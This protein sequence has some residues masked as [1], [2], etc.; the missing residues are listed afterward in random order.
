MAPHIPSSP[1]A[2]ATRAFCPPWAAAQHGVHTMVS[3]TATRFTFRCM[4]CFQALYATTD[5]VGNATNC[6]HC[7]HELI[8]PE[9]TPER[10][11]RAKDAPADVPSAAVMASAADTPTTTR[12]APAPG[13]PMGEEWTNADIERQLKEDMYVDPSEMITLSTVTSSRL[14]R[15]VGYIIDGM[16]L[17]TATVG[18]FLLVWTLSSAG[19]VKLEALSEDN[20]AVGTVEMVNTLCV[21]YFLPAILLLVQWWLIATR[22]QS[23]AKFLLGMRIV[24]VGGQNPGFLQ[25]VVLRNWV[26]ALL[27][28]L[29]FFALLDAA[30]IINDSKRCIHDLIAGTHVVD[31]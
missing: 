20:H 3:A 29:P 18:G 2:A 19:L 13:A 14:K 10:I 21:L 9:A 5:E 28:M 25:G 30:F 1:T 6:V 15:L 24:T 27:N 4:R 11:E 26:R 17:A 16:L 23:I 7:G 8:V 31:V 12:S 22:G